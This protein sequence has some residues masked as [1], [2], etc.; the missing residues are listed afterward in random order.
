M[1][2]ITINGVL[3]MPVSRAAQVGDK[4]MVHGYTIMAHKLTGQR[5]PKN[6]PPHNGEFFTIRMLADDGTVL[7][8]DERGFAGSIYVT[9][10]L[11]LEPQVVPTIGY[12]ES[13]IG[14]MDLK[15]TV[16]ALVV[17]LLKNNVLTMDDLVEAYYGVGEHPAGTAGLQSSTDSGG[18]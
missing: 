18:E 6:P 2:K 17:V 1:T 7:A 8:V 11:V 12:V 13:A 14:H 9:E 5:G 4:I 10:Y 15:R 3:H 16:L